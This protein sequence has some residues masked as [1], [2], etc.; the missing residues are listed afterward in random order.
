MILLSSRGRSVPSS[1]ALPALSAATESLFLMEGQWQQVRRAH[2]Q[3]RQVDRWHGDLP[4]LLLERCWLR[5]TCVSVS[6]L[7]TRL[8]PDCTQE[9]PEL[10][11]YRE[12][13]DAGH[14]SWEAQRIC[15]DDFGSEACRQALRQ[16]WA[17]QERGHQGWTLQ[18]YLQF[19]KDYRSQFSPGRQRS[20]PLMV[21]ARSRQEHHQLHWLLP[22]GSCGR[23]SMRDT[24]P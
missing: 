4:V 18:T 17:A 16:F 10:R 24:C 3:L 23:R 9:A 12:L 7:A 22:D 8:P 13:V 2:D 19:L 14:N 21:L 6:E 15:W 5:L 20:L 1:D 11:R